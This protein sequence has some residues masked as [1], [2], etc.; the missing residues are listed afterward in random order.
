[1]FAYVYLFAV[2]TLEASMKSTTWKERKEALETLSKTLD[3][4]RRLDARGNYVQLIEILKV[5]L[6]VL[7]I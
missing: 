6:F 7:W 1:V 3:Q 4:H 5:C 2:E